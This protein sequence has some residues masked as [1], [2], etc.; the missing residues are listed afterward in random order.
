MRSACEC[1]FR[2]CLCIY[3]NRSWT[4]P[5]VGSISRDHNAAWRSIFQT[6]YPT[7]EEMFNI[8]YGRW[9]TH[10][11]TSGQNPSST[12]NSNSRKVKSRCKQPIFFWTWVPGADLLSGCAHTSVHLPEAND[13]V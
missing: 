4:C 3:P 2:V 6:T 11:R 8:P 7:P 9:S 13:I 5:V 12:G 10:L 1:D